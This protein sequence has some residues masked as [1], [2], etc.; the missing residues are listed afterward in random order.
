MERTQQVR[1]IDLFACLSLFCVWKQTPSQDTI[2]HFTPHTVHVR[3]PN[4]SFRQ[5]LSAARRQEDKQE[6]D[7]HQKGRHEP[8]LQRSHDL[9]CALQCPAGEC[10]DCLYT[11]AIEVKKK[12]EEINRDKSQIEFNNKNC[13][14]TQCNDM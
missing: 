8:H 1:V 14:T 10:P 11:K 7:L 3:L 2:Y 9:L 5:S 13:L 4:R 12:D 6:E